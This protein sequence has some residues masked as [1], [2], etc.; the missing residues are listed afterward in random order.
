MA[1]KFDA[2][3]N[4]FIRR[5]VDAY[6]KRRKR[7]EMEGVK[8]LPS[9]QSIKEIKQMFKS[10]SATR[11]EIKRRLNALDKFNLKSAKQMITLTM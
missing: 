3:L 10:E 9:K 6:N 8:Y 7:A 1:I 4:K 2:E 5:K 11:D